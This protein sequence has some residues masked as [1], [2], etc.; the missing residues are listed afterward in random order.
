MLPRPMSELHPEPDESGEPV[1][2]GRAARA[3]L[4]RGLQ[5]ALAGRE[6]PSAPDVPSL[7]EARE[8]RA[9]D[10]A[11]AR[12]I[13]LVHAHRATLSTRAALAVALDRAPIL[14]DDG[15]RLERDD[16]ERL[17]ATKE[18]RRA[19][20]PL[21][22]S[23]A[24]AAAPFEEEREEAEGRFTRVLAEALTL[25]G[26]AVP[27]VDVATATVE[28]FLADI[29]DAAEE[30]RAALGR[31]GHLPLEDPLALARGLDLPD[32]AGFAEP[33]VRRLGRALLDAAGRQRQREVKALRVPRALA[34][35]VIAAD[36]GPVRTA[37][38]PSV[39][40]G[41][42]LALSSSLG[43]AVAL[44][45]FAPKALAAPVEEE[46][47]LLGS[48]LSFGA[49][50]AVVRRGVLDET[51]A[52]AERRARVLAATRLLGAQASALAARVLLEGEGREALRDSL[53]STFGSDPPAELLSSLLAPPW[54]GLVG[55][56]TSAGELG[57][58]VVR[59]A[60]GSALALGL[61]DRYDEAFVLVPSPYELFGAARE[62]LVDRAV[63]A[64]DLAGARVDPDHP[65]R[66]L[67]E[68][69]A[70]LL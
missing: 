8:R 46:A 54:P 59:L 33:N 15:S 9:D 47:L 37:A 66:S 49:S 31:A 20:A 12:E 65:G 6:P 51:E 56:R 26:D 11:A 60:L 27:S 43:A 41:R 42:F 58:R 7:D 34:S 67:V 68:W 16:A 38:C 13:A 22:R 53:G 36:D 40:A 61:R 57:A 18:E 69:T 62:A 35:V 24:R 19:F 45:L 5:D 23:I 21:R 3:H 44:S 30:A 17:L 25:P 39:T 32:P 10:P 14:L 4:A 29:A 50:T 55:L 64:L 28:R 70:E 63:G 52:E 48:A 1:V 2:L